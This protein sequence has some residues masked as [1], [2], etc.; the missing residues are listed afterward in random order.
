[1]K[2]EN[3][4]ISDFSSAFQ[5]VL[6]SFFQ[7]LPNLASALLALVAGLLLAFLLKWL[8]AFVARSVLK[9]FSTKVSDDNAIRENSASV[10]KT[11]GNIVFFLIVFLTGVSVLKRLGLVVI[12]EW[13]EQVSVHLPKM[14][15]A[16]VILVLG[17]KLKSFV[18][19]LLFKSFTRAR[20]NQ[21]KSL[22]N[23]LG[24]FVFGVGLIVAIDQLGV[25]MGLVVVVISVLGGVVTGGVALTFALGAKSTV[26]NILSCHQVKRHV[27]VGQKIKHR[28][29][30]GSV[31]AVGPTFIVLATD[32]GDAFIPGNQLSEEPTFILDGDS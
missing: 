22:S 12:S 18:S 20:I 8:T 16:F 27:K 29:I 26:S 15:A 9:L 1:M 21:A 11:L 6:Q 25:D 5:D 24:W 31:K 10:S 13:L 17:W 19:E 23:L 3:K 2:T 14:I 28:G 4:I 7:I 32:E 30:Q